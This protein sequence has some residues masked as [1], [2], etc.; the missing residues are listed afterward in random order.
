MAKK[1]ETSGEPV[2]KKTRIVS[3]KVAAAREV[4]KQTVAVAKDAL[5]AELKRIKADSKL[6]KILGDPAQRELIK[7][8]I[9]ER[10]A[11]EKLANSY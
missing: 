6:E 10:E 8:G 1:K 3:P 7:R 9:E 11:A 5:K 2:E 4:Y